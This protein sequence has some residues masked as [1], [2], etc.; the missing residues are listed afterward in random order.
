MLMSTERVRESMMLLSGSVQML[1]HCFLYR[2][3]MFTA[4]NDYMHSESLPYCLVYGVQ[5]QQ[6]VSL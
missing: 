5:A 1:V 2:F 3:V 6:Q 4:S